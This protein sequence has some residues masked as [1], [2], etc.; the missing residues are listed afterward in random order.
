MQNSEISRPV[1]EALILAQNLIS[2]G[3]PHKA[4][5][6]LKSYL[7]TNPQDAAEAL[8]LLGIALA[9][10][11]RYE[12]AAEAYQ[13]AL[14][15][16]P[17]FTACFINFAVTL[18]ALGNFEGA[19]MALE[20][21]LE[22]DPDNVPALNNYANLLRDIGELEKAK[23]VYEKALSLNAQIPEPWVNYAIVLGDLGELKK[24]EG[25]LMEALK[26]FPNFPYAIKAL[27]N[28]L[29]RAGKLAEAEYYLRL[30]LVLTPRDAESYAHLGGLLITMEPGFPKEAEEILYTALKLDPRNA[31]AY[32]NLGILYSILGKK[33]EAL[34][35]FNKA[36]SL[37][38]NEPK[39]LKQI[40]FHKDI[41]TE[42]DE[43]FRIL[44]SLGKSNLPLHKRLE[45]LYALAHA[46][47]T[48]KQDDLYFETLI[49]ANK[50][51]RQTIHYSH[52]TTKKSADTKIRI[53]T[54]ELVRKYSGYGFPTKLPVFI[55]GMP[56][57][58]TTLMESILD[59]HPEVYGAG[60]LKLMGECLKDGILIEG[61]LFSS[62]EDTPQTA[63]AAPQGFFEIGRRYYTALRRL[64]P[65]SKRIV[66]KMPGNI[67]N[68]GIIILSLP[69]AKIIHMRRHPLDTII[70]C[71]EQNFAE[72]H[73][74]SYDLKDLFLLYNEYIRLVNHW[75]RVFKENF[76][77]IEYERLVL[78]PEETVSDILRYLELPYSE[79]CI[80]FYEKKRPVKTASYEQ[81]RKPLYTS[82]IGRWR[83]YEKYLEPYLGLLSDEAKQE[84]T[85]IEEFINSM[86]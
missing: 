85:Q 27:G 78:K 43:H 69:Q 47:S 71:F 22:I 48:M 77:E 81:V 50:L 15:I 84:I 65:Q 6:F 75:R 29:T 46:Y 58:G 86:K 3:Q 11:K 41:I 10:M 53:F 36:Y 12:E 73:E 83:K 34:Q 16:N 7:K 44:K 66:D 37:K 9:S 51:K 52:E 49:E 17:D 45:V 24:A 76:V 39:L 54:E 5:K 62:S 42:Q 64:A 19:K 60:E 8:N 2:E 68:L 1:S 67:Y 59:A 38:P 31:V 56:R 18:K 55:V 25:V 35:C 33:K 80:K 13:E 26:K 74:Y 21:V 79:E 20:K 72:G 63:L 14:S 4:E 70:S 28:I 30:S 61:V 23:E 57:S 32:E 82:S 40:I